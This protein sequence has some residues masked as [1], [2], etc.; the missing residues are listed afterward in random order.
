MDRG[1]SG[2]WLIW[3]MMKHKKRRR[4]TFTFSFLHLLP[5]YQSVVQTY[6]NTIGTIIFLH[7]TIYKKL[8]TLCPQLSMVKCISG[9]FIVD[10][11]KKQKHFYSCFFC[12]SRA[13][14]QLPL[15]CL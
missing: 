11:E 2:L 9:F 6:L 7:I 15:D 4:P 12:C 5:I 14:P 1:H 8:L 3:C 13:D 10:G